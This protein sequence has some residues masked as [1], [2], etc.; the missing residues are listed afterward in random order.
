MIEYIKRWNVWRKGN[1]NG[2][3]HQILVLVGLRQS[4]SMAFILMPDEL[5]KFSNT[6]YRG[7][8]VEG[9]EE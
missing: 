5:N 8:Y 9:K 2:I 4:P 6:F 1:L 3:G 7:L